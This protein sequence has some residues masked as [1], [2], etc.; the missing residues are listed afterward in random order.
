MVSVI[1]ET[2][3]PMQTFSVQDIIS[4]N[5]IKHLKTNKKTVETKLIAIKARTTELELV[6]KVKTS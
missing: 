3:N 1:K 2:Q 6:S 5:T 4:Q